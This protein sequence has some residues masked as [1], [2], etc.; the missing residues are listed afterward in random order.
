MLER[1]KLADEL[2]NQFAAPQPP[3]PQMRETDPIQYLQL[4]EAY[5]DAKAEFD[6]RVNAIREGLAVTQGLY[7]EHG[8]VVTAEKRQT[9]LAALQSAIPALFD[10]TTRAATFKTIAVGAER[11]GFTPQEVANQWV[12]HRFH[13]LALLASR[14]VKLDQE[15]PKVAK[16]VEG[17]PPVPV[18][19]PGSRV[20][21][22]QSK[23]LEHAR[24]MKRLRHSGSADDAVAA[25]NARE[26]I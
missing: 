24:A 26:G 14:A 7:D 1:L 22:Q 20:T 2:V 3:D 18:A 6:D 15:K 5:R 17:K 8:Q 23:Q 4:R 13:R 16:K 9:E 21:E 25:L 11:A 12:D 10:P 19:R